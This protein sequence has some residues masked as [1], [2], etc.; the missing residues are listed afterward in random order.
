[1][2]PDVWAEGALAARAAAA[3]LGVSESTFRVL[4]KRHGW[5]RKRVPGARAGGAGK[6]VYPK[7]ALAA[8]L[9]GCPS[10]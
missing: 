5:P 4:A 7:A 8:F 3:F 2:T 10:A 9:A 6:V 1:M